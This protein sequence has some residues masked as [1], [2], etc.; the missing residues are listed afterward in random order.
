M[1]LTPEQIARA[2]RDPEYR[3]SLSPKEL[4]ELPDSPV[5]EP[6]TDALLSEDDLESVAGGFTGA[7]LGCGT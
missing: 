7:T 1:P 6:N 3:K 5:G 4:K 2:W